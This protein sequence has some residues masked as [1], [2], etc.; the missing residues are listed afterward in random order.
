MNSYLQEVVDLHQLIEARFARGEG[1]VEAMMQHFLP[2]FSMVSPAG[3]QFGLQDVE[4]LFERNA[5]SQPGL[6]I[7]LKDLES[8]HQWADGALVRYREIHSA[9]GKDE[10]IRVSTAVLVREEG[11]VKWLRLHETWAV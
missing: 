8:L 7:E 1:S 3:L 5:G 6:N 10:T 4:Q 2:N 9:E 11:R